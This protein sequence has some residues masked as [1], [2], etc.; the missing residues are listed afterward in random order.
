MADAARSMLHCSI[1][2]VFTRP[3]THLPAAPPRLATPAVSIGSGRGLALALAALALGGFTIGTTE[4]AA[5]SLL[6]QIAAGMG[7]DEPAA[8]HAI[9]AYALGVVVGAPTLAVL[10]ARW[11]KRSLLI[12]LMAVCA[13]ANLASAL[14][15]GY[16]W[17][18]GFRFLSGL[19]H[20]A[21][22]GVGALVASSLVPRERRTQAVG[23]MMLGLTAATI[24]G[25]P[26]ATV[27]SQWGGWR[28]G[29]AIVA[30]LATL[31]ALAV[32]FFV[33][34]RPA[35]PGASPLREL[36]ALRSHQV[37][38]T[39]GTGAI[40]F[41]GMFAVYTYLAGTMTHV[42]G[43]SPALLPVA[44]VVFGAGM[45]VGTLVCA[46]GAD[47]A[48]MPTAGLCLLF[49]TVVLALFAPA[50]H[51]VG[52]L[53]PIIALVGAG[54]GLGTVLQ[55]R[56]MD[57]AGRGQNLAAALNH[58]AFNTANALGPW[59]GGMA[60]SAGFGWASTGAVGVALGL[61]GLAI[62]AISFALDR[63]DR[64]SVARQ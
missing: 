12:A 20:G 5:M 59:L 32:F 46:W 49:S 42:T 36:D 7:V 4:F 63:R 47:R 26:L 53:L 28:S 31:T 30:G 33:P 1:G 54:G 8:G 17:L 62:W 58:S 50:A 40:G 2:Q 22:F 48:L 41:G 44:L 37:W 14:A 39:L 10:G 43:A 51:H 61:G 35:E 15:P 11:P 34:N 6:P 16:G 27:I 60:I 21:Y 23:R 25:V 52:T 56:L 45:T 55:A 18:L 57:V 29:F 9:S 3:M 38:L 13:L 64:L 19:P 24:A